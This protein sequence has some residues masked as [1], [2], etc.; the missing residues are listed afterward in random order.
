MVIKHQLPVRRFWLAVM[1]LIIVALALS[2]C[3]LINL[4][5]DE[6]AGD[7]TP[8]EET[9]S[10]AQVTPLTLAPTLAQATVGG[11]LAPPTLTPSPDGAGGDLAPTP[12]PPPTQIA[13][14]TPEGGEEGAGG[15]ESAQTGG[16]PG[17]SI[18]PQL[19]EPGEIIIVQGSGFG[20]EEEVTLHWA[21]PDGKTG[22]AYVNVDTDANGTF[23]V[24]LIVPPGDQWPGGKPKEMDY[25]QLRAKSE[26]LGDFYY[27]ANFR[28]VKRFNPVTSL[29]QT[30]TNKD[31][32]YEI[33][34]PNAWTWSW[35]E[36]DTSDVRFVSPKSIGK[37]FIRIATTT[38][39]TSAIKTI[40][41]LEAAGQTY[42]TDDISA[43]SYPGTQV[44]ASNGLVVWF[45]PAN[46]RT[47]VISFMDDEGRFY[48]LIAVSFR[49]K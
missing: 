14:P 25:I 42:T 7:G 26:S 19:G 34:L 36:D 11:T 48:E 24:G 32:G 18:N 30:Y 13:A 10:V 5:R 1:G 27:W 6:S 12:L 17:I 39:V 20:A 15:A 9:E 40:M 21:T 49:L 46:G 16:G 38:N 45:I 44:T 33:D 23:Q 43:G 4:A 8:P 37:G 35:V 22:P 28:Y 3:N 31:Y 2:G 47:Y 29:V 41:P